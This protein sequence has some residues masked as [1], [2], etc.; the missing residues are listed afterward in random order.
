MPDIAT[1]IQQDGM[2]ATGV[3][4]RLSLVEG[5]Y[6]S[7]QRVVSIAEEALLLLLL[8]PVEPLLLPRLHAVLVDHLLSATATVTEGVGGGG[9]CQSQCEG[10]QCEVGASGGP[11]CEVGASGHL[12]VLVRDVTHHPRREGGQRQ[13]EGEG[14]AWGSL[15]IHGA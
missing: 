12:S 4:S 3:L 15:T 2:R 6:G 5:R 13:W 11:R 7:K 1:Q 10:P 14:W 8:D 9:G